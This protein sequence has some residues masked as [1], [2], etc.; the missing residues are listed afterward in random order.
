LQDLLKEDDE[1]DEVLKIPKNSKNH[2]VVMRYFWG[3]HQRF[4]KSLCVALKVPSAIALAQRA[5]GEG[6]CV[7]IGLQSTG[8]AAMERSMKNPDQDSMDDF[9]SSPMVLLKTVIKKIFPL[10]PMTEAEKRNTSINKLKGQAKKK[11]GKSRFVY[12]KVEAVSKVLFVQ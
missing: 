8:E 6:K 9:I 11:A 12:S 4:F 10:P 5:L 3:S 7:V 1:D 2:G